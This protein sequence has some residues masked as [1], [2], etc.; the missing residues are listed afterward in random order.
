MLIINKDDTITIR[1][2]FT[3]SKLR[4]LQRAFNKLV[5]FIARQSELFEFNSEIL[6][7]ICLVVDNIDLGEQAFCD[8][9]RGKV[10]S[11]NEGT[12]RFRK[13]DEVT[14]K[15]DLVT[16][17]TIEEIVRIRKSILEGI[18]SAFQFKTEN[19]DFNREETD[20]IYVLVDFLCDMEL[21]EAQAVEC[22][23]KNKKQAK[24]AA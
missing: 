20:S 2:N 22:I 23:S 16:N 3:G 19:W 13:V 9:A 11:L 15:L 6:D 8:I 10:P 5:W 4:S 18:S 14:E 21:T 1:T 7:G 17:F 24:K 12:V